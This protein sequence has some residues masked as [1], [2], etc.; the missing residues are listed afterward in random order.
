MG[1]RTVEQYKESLRD[2]RRVTFGARKVEDI[3]RHRILG[4]T[5]AHYRRRL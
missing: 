4:I 2:G 1:I 3:T 5:C